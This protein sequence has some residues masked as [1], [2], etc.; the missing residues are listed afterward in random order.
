MNSTVSSCRM[1]SRLKESAL[2]L[3]QTATTTATM[4]HVPAGANDVQGSECICTLDGKT[5]GAGMANASGALKA[6][7]RPVAAVT[8]PATVTAGQGVM[9][10]GGAS[11]GGPGH[12][13]ATYHWASVG[14]QNLSIAGGTEDN[15]DDTRPTLSL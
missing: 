4:C 11:A 14:A 8:V 6:A 7:V 3:P 13:I 12:T 15:A 1:I 10:P 9:L 2:P 5:C